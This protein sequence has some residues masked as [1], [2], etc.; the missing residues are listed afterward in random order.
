MSPTEPEM[1]VWTPPGLS[2]AECLGVDLNH[3]QE[4]SCSM[5]RPLPSI[6]QRTCLK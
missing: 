6:S 4:E 2:Q 1:M 3:S 5:L